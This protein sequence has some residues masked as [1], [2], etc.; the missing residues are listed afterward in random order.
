M[1]NRAEE[2]LGEQQLRRDLLELESKAQ[3][4]KTCFDLP[5]R[6]KHSPL[7]QALAALFV[8]ST[9]H[10]PGVCGPDSGTAKPR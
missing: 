1:N 10:L 3:K 5:R 7:R 9:G 4:A 6:A 8:A 2:T